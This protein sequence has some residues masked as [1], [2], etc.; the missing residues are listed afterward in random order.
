[1]LAGILS[2]VLVVALS[3]SPLGDGD[4]VKVH[5]QYAGYIIS[6]K[7]VSRP[8]VASTHAKGSRVTCKYSRWFASGRVN[9]GLE[10]VD[11]GSNPSGSPTDR[12]A[13]YLVE[14]S[15]GYRDVVRIPKGRDAGVTPEQ[16]ARRAYRLIPVTSPKVLTAPPRGHDG[17][18]GLPHWFYLAKGEW[19]A[20]SKRLRIGGV[21]AEATAAPQRMT[22]SLGDGKTITCDGPGAAYDPT[23]SADEQHST[24]SYRYLHPRSAYQATVSV[25]WGGTW[26]GSGGTGGTLP[27]IT[28]SVTFQIRVVEAQALVTKE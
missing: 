9:G 19:A 2:P 21:W 26:H 16:L 24:C 14:C 28:R 5:T 1:M 10:F 7:Q 11:P 25:T 27:P 6:G 17:L 22:V 4:E 3:T 15:D 12:G 8:A 23:K 20:R 18:V 13:Y